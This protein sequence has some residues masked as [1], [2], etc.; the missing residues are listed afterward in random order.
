MLK[1][2]KVHLILHLVEC[3]EQF[4]PTSAFNSERYTT[5]PNRD[6]HV[7]IPYLAQ[8]RILCVHNA[9]STAYSCTLP[10]QLCIPGAYRFL[11]YL[12]MACNVSR[13]MHRNESMCFLYPC[14]YRNV[15]RSR[16]HGCAQN[17]RAQFQETVTV[18]QD[19]G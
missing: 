3:M 4:G 7:T 18:N 11:H 14:R 15:H 10:N 19:G 6:V 2:Q 5:Q 12:T 8:S 17:T 1:K 13:L 9:V 16:S